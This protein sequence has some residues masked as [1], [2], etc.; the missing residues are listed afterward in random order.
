MREVFERL[1]DGGVVD[2]NGAGGIDRIAI[3]ALQKHLR[4]FRICVNALVGILG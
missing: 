4:S 1:L 3:L 2:S